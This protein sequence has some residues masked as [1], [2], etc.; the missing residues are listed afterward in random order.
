MTHTFLSCLVCLNNQKRNDDFKIFFQYSLMMCGFHVIF[1][2]FCVHVDVCFIHV[3]LYV[4]K[5]IS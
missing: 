4:A 1:Y 3:Q 5:K 2:H